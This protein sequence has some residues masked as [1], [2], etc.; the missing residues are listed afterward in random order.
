MVKEAS[1]VRNFKKLIIPAIVLAVLVAAYVIIDSLPEKKEETE[2]T[3]ESI[4][5]FNFLKD[6]LVEIK[7]ERGDELLWFRYVTIQVEE[8]EIKEDG[9]VEKKTVDRKVWQAVEPA[10]MR[11]N[12]ST[13][14]T[15][16]WNAN[17]LK[18]KKLVEEN[19]T[20]LSIY[21]LDNPVKLTFILKDG[22]QNVLFVGNAIPTG[23]SYYA[24]KEGDPA[25]YTIGSYEAEK[26]LLTKL[27]LIN[28]DLYEEPY[29]P[30]DFTE[31]SYERKGAK[32]F[33]STSDG[34]GNWFLS[35]PIE[36]EANFSSI[37]SIL[38]SLGELTVSEYVDE[39]VEDLS[40]YGLKTPSYVISY[41][42][43]GNSY[44][45]S[46]GSKNEAGKFYAVM[47]DE[48]LVFTIPGSTFP[49]LDKPI[50]EIVTSFVHLQNISEVA[51]LRVEIDGR[52]D[53]S[54]IK[55]DNEDDEKSTY[56]FNGTLLTGEKDD[57][58]ISAFKKYYQGVIGILVDKVSLDAEPVLENPEVTITYTLHSGEKIVVELVSAPDNVYYYA[59]KNGKY[60]GIMVR[61]KQLD[62]E[63]RNGLRV[64]YRKFIE[65]LK[66]RDE[67]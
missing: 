46:L 6:D 44:K 38:E 7:I 50:E 45:L 52:T 11:P 32:V 63:N 16:A 5:I 66:G 31:L 43:K 3:S 37:Y 24:R 14:D 28:K 41:T 58:Y 12:T 27:D 47:N 65:K 57:E 35:Y 51:E 56:E 20:D 21:G 25:V 60:T 49:F 8:E 30:E 1:P 4:E 59:F 33:D 40:K 2:T 22:K 62:D 36:T 67:K 54:N 17:T 13:V 48:N 34:K 55:V 9:T 26:F 42:A 18:A 39:D 15:I 64:G 53:V 19:P 10:D 23:G 29:I 61:K